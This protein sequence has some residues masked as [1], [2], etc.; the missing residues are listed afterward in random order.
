MKKKSLTINIILGSSD[1][2]P[3]ENLLINLDK[4]KRVTQFHKILSTQPY[5][6]AIIFALSKG[7][8]VNLEER[9][10]PA[11]LTLTEDGAHWNLIR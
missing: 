10:K 5:E 8:L 9:E 3:K 4:A 2:L 7:K 11:Q 1:V 6:N